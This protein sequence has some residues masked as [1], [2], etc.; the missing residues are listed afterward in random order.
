MEDQM[1]ARSDAALPRGWLV[2]Q[3]EEVGSSTPPVGAEAGDDGVRRELARELH[4]QV[5]QELT[6]TLIDLE[7]FKR[8]PYDEQSVAD[9]VD[10]VQGS[11]RR[12]L[13]EL[14]QLLYD[15]RD[16]EAWQ[17]TFMTSLRDFA[18]RYDERTGVR[19]NVAV[20]GDWPSSIRS[21]SAKQLQRIIHEAVNNAR[22]HGGARAVWVSLL[23]EADL[24]RVTIL[25][26]G[27]GLDPYY[28]EGPGLGI[29]GMRERA[30]LL[31]GTITVERAPGQGTLV[32]VDFPRTALS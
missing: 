12:T 22:L 19:I 29:L 6:V 28:A 8:Q 10:Q 30:L 13:R 4:D 2:D 32:R 20:D 18:A 5:V 1:T 11:L 16:E 24:A 17:P 3:P 25:D 27:R 9:Q 26:D 21:A 7:N 23:A 14:R 31:G 15:L